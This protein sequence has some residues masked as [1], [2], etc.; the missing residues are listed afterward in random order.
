MLA[1]P[2]TEVKGLFLTWINDK[3]C[4]PRG[5]ERVASCPTGVSRAI[6]KEASLLLPMVCYSRKGKREVKKRI[7][8]YKRPYPNSQRPFLDLEKR[9]SFYFL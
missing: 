1:R 2:V 8:F 5:E 4:F 9:A 3:L 7:F 6:G